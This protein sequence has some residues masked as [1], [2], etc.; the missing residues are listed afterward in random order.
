MSTYRDWQNNKFANPNGYYNDYYTNP[1]FRLDNERVKYQ[2]ANVNGTLDVTYK[3][4]PWLS[5]FDR[6]S[7]MN[8]TRT[9]KNSV[10]K[11]IHS[12]YAKSLAYVPAGIDQGDGKGITRAG[13]DFLGSTSDNINTENILNNEFQIQASKDF[14]GFSLKGFLGFSL[15]D[16]KTKSVS[17]NSSSIVVPGTF[18][19]DNRLG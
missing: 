4:M 13:T 11:F 5:L 9:Q 7:G 6:V 16:R 3:L 18:N 15:Y 2:D 10:G 12:D 17:V 19:V 1:Y 8:N 14:K